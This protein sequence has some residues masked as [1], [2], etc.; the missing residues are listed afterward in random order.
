[1]VQK[2]KHFKGTVSGEVAQ[3][4]QSI[5]AAIA[6]YNTAWA[7]L[8]EWLW[9]QANISEYQKILCANTPI[10]RQCANELRKLLTDFKQNLRVL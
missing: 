2:L 5:L 6:N 7:A 1:M 3:V 9:E 8:F 10:Q 4:T